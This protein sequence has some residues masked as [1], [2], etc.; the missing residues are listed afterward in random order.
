MCEV[1]RATHLGLMKP[2]ALKMLRP[3]FTTDPHCIERFHR[4]AL[5]MSKLQ[6]PNI[7]EVYGLGYFSSVFQTRPYIALELVE[8]TTLSEYAKQHRDQLLSR[9]TAVPIFMQICQAL[10]HAHCKGII[11]RDLKPANVMIKSD[12][13]S[14]K[15]IDFGVAKILTDGGDV[16][17]LTLMGETVGSVIYMS[18]EQCRGQE[19]DQRTDI[20]S[21]GCLMYEVLTG[22]PPLSGDTPYATMHKH[23]FE[24]PEV[25]PHLDNEFG[26]VVMNALAKNPQERPQSAKELMNAL[27]Q[28]AWATQAPKQSSRASTFYR[29]KPIFAA[30]LAVLAAATIWLA[31]SCAARLARLATPASLDC[32]FE[33]LAFLENNF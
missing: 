1:Y 31:E 6:H 11:H 5:A 26:T 9:D 8:G 3:R 25:K 12:G 4:E 30:A 32:Q 19:I 23:L 14:V 20:Y 21:M 16:Q 29:A 15:V 7:V 33:R 24:V 10:E 18:P 17:R 27:A 28:C 13:R 22:M 2:V